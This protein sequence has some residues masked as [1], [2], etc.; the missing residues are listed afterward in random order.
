MKIIYTYLCLAAFLGDTFNCFSQSTTVDSL[1]KV[2]K[3]QEDGPNRVRTLAALCFSLEK[4]GDYQN[5]LSHSQNL[6]MI[7]KKIKD[8]EGQAFGHQ[9]WGM[10][11]CYITPGDYL[12]ANAELDLAI[13]LFNS[14]NKKSEAAYCYS[15]KG[16]TN[17]LLLA[18]WP[19]ALQ[20][21]YIALKIF[22]SIGD[23]KGIIEVNGDIC[24]L[25]WDQ[26]RLNEA[27]IKSKETLALL[28]QNNDFVQLASQLGLTA[29]IYQSMG[30]NELS[31]KYAIASLNVYKRIGDKGPSW[32]IPYTYGIIAENSRSLGY[33]ALKHSDSLNA[34]K[35][36]KKALSYNIERLKLEKKGDMSE[37]SGYFGIGYSYLDLIEVSSASLRK[38]YLNKS[39]FH[40]TQAKRISL[41]EDARRYLMLSY[42]GLSQADSINGD[43]KAAFENYKQYVT[44][45][46]SIYNQE[47]ISK[48]QLYKARYEMDLKEDEVKLLST[49]NKLNA[50]LAKA[51][52]QQ[53]K[54]AFI[55]VGFILVLSGYGIYRYRINAK[56]QVREQLIT[57]RLRVSRELHDEIGSTLSGIAMYSH[58]LKEQLKTADVTIA[59]NSANIIQNSAGSMV[60]K[61]N[62]I[63]WFINPEQDTMQKITEQLEEYAIQM[64]SACNMKVETVVEKAVPDL[65][66]AVVHRR[67]IYLI[68]KEAINNSVKYSNGDLLTI[69]ISC[70][71]ASKI[72]FEVSD[73]GVGFD[74][75]A[76]NRGNGLKNMHQRA[77]EIGAQL[78]FRTEAGAGTTVL[79]HYNIASLS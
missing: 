58:L 1:Q 76:I 26:N 46:D 19:Q 3:Y 60:T 66:L 79:M 14:I 41:N 7:S 62:D 70:D 15:I 47:D 33:E 57:E 48:T 56:N 27:L 8:V 39:Y 35:H 5:L 68:C 13:R 17:S 16:R 2:F 20:N 75:A 67:N 23:K 72:K 50:A 45:R 44:L 51:E 73:N 74:H 59:E 25:Y 64:A 53:K 40:L 30:K 31:V 71:N 10:A 38:T 77:K 29:N 11:K 42:L 52:N 49:Q 61:L 22:E 6:V 34:R 63:I 36:F 54:F 24:L 12:S 37:K 9:Y 28:K 55:I 78:I 69:T 32:G 43:F 65:K 4:Q 18:D 21:H